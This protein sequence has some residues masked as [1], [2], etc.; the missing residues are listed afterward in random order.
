MTTLSKRIYEFGPY[1]LDTA[2]RVLMRDDQPVALAPKA[3]DVLL[4]LVESSGHIVEKDELM[5]RVWANSFVEEG[6]L[7]V[8]VSVLRKALEG[9]QYIETVPHRGYRFVA[10]VKELTTESATLLVR[11]RTT[12]SVTIEESEED[13]EQ[14]PAKTPAKRTSKTRLQLAI[15]C[16]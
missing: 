9:G 8:T 14:E 5:N 3:F 16:V 7:K 4:M 6:N 11:E 2:E 12:S 10:S 1:R 13:E 15:A